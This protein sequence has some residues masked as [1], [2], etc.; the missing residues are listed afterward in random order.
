MDNTRSLLNMSKMSPWGTENRI[1]MQ[2][3]REIGVKHA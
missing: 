2:F 1:N 3:Y